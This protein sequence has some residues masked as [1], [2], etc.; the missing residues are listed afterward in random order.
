MFE[1]RL[2][3]SRAQCAFAATPREAA[4]TLRSIIPNAGVVYI[5]EFQ[6]QKLVKVLKYRD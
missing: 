4:E 2:D 3:N 5:Y 6:T 1:A